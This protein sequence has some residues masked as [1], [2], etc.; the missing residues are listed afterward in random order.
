MLRAMSRPTLIYFPMRGR[1]ELLRVVLAEAGIEYDEQPIEQKALAGSPD[2]PFGAVPVW[3]EADGFR[4]AQSMAI[5]R[6]VASGAGLMGKTARER[7]LCDQMLGAFEDVRGEVRRMF[8]ASPERRAALD[9]ELA[10]VI[11]PRWLGRLDRVLAANGGGAGFVVGDQLT[12]AD[13][14]L[15]YL[16]ESLRDNGYAEAV[17]GQPRLAA[18]FERI[19]ARPRIAAWTRSPRRAPPVQVPR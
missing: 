18:F 8:T 13:L 19:G 3:V 4:L 16:L 15:Y 9:K 1:A 11:L 12:V 10:E 7:A 2:L 6:H 17:A 14:A 5:V